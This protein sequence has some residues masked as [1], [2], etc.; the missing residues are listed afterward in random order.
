[1]FSDYDK[2]NIDRLLAGE[3][4]WFNARLLRLISRADSNNREL[5]RKSYPEQVKAYE[6][7]VHGEIWK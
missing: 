1:M 2:K 5:L 3:G 6:N 7:Y 4:T